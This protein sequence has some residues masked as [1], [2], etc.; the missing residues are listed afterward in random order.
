MKPRGVSTVQPAGTGARSPT[1]D[2]AVVRRMPP[3]LPA[4]AALLLRP[5]LLAVCAA[6]MV[7]AGAADISVPIGP[8][9]WVFDAAGSCTPSHIAGAEG[10]T[11]WS[12]GTLT[13]RTCTSACAGRSP[14]V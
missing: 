8:N 2:G 5:L 6:L 4:S 9:S 7:A 11:Q 12:D 1:A 14:S 3:A 13:I 10:I